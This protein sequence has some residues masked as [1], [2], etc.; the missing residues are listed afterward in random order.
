MTELP[1]IRKLARKKMNERGIPYKYPELIHRLEYRLG[2][3]FSAEIRLG[4][5]K[6]FEICEIDMMEGPVKDFDE[7]VDRIVMCI[8]LFEHKDQL[9]AI[10]ML[11]RGYNCLDGNHL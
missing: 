8:T 9:A 6:M 2:Y 4:F 3:I 1:E 7:I 5:D 11:L 10:T